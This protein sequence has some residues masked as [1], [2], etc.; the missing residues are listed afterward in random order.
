MIWGIHG[1]GSGERNRRSEHG[2]GVGVWAWLSYRGRG[3][4]MYFILFVTMREEEISACVFIRTFFHP[5]TWRPAALADSLE[6]S[7]TSSV[8]RLVCVSPRLRRASHLRV[9][10]HLTRFS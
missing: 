5:I 8:Y 9:K 7:I 2:T 4:E 10:I 1:D 3:L 6:G